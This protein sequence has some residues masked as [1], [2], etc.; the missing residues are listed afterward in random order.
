MNERIIVARR[1]LNT[2]L[3]LALA[4]SISLDSYLLAVTSTADERCN[5]AR[6]KTLHESPWRQSPS[7]R[8]VNADAEVHQIMS[9]GAAASRRRPVVR[10]GHDLLL[11]PG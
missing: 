2:E 7:R 11:S 9:G 3:L 4:Y 10:Y 5:Q 1:N 8:P 6:Y